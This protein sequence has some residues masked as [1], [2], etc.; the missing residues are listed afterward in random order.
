MSVVSFLGAMSA[1]LILSNPD[2]IDVNGENL[3]GE[4]DITKPDE[5][6]L[7]LPFTIKNVG[8]FDIEDLTIRIVLHMEYS[9]INYSTPGVNE[10]VTETIFDKTQSFDNIKSGDS[11]DDSFEGASKH[12]ISENIPDPL[13]ELD[14]TQPVKFYVDISLS[15]KYS[16]GLLT[17]A[18]N[19]IDYK[20]QE[21]SF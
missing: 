1:I 4:F 6:N 19:I 8:F 2:N 17:L 13:N 10:T 16:L 18:V 12:F 15:M 5:L 9:H 20:M 14:R 11:L 7:T 21:L 3:E